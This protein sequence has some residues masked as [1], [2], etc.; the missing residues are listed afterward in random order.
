MRFFMS[1]DQLFIY[2]FGISSLESLSEI[3]PGSNNI[4][5]GLPYIAVIPSWQTFCTEDISHTDKLHIDKSHAMIMF[6]RIAHSKNGYHLLPK[7]TI[8]CP[9]LPFVAQIFHVLP[10]ITT[11]CQILPFIAKSYHLLPTGTIC[12]PGQYFAPLNSKIMVT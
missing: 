3:L 6:R 12:L 5:P 11:Y 2:L 1:I 8:C 10:K 7:V 9:K 4:F